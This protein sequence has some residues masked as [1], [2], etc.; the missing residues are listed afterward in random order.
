VT[1]S[2]DQT[3]GSWGLKKRKRCNKIISE[4]FPNLEKEMLIHAQEVSRKPNRCDKN[5]ISL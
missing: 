5:R 3:C 2:K 1:P 4:N